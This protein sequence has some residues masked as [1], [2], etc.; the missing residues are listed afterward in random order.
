M[1]SL[2]NQTQSLEEDKANKKDRPLPSKRITLQTA[3]IIR[4][5]VP[6]FNLAWSAFYG[7]RVFY[8]ALVFCIIAWAYNEAGLSS[9][10]WAI[11]NLCIGLGVAVIEA[12]ACLVAGASNIFPLN[13]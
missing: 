6:M 2:A 13:I 7:K 8:A 9:G 4:W 10:H 5:I 3:K 12:G 11:R 1:N